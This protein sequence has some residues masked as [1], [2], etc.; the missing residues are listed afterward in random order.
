MNDADIERIQDEMDNII[1]LALPIHKVVM[2]H[3]E[4]VDELDKINHQ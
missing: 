2:G 3:Q 4:I 1:Q